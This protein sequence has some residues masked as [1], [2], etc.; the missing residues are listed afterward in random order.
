[1]SA[2]LKS[3]Q[4]SCPIPLEEFERSDR[5]FS[6]AVVM[7]GACYSDP[8]FFDFEME[9]VYGREWV[10]VGRADLIPKVGDYFTITVVGEPLIVVRNANDEIRVMSGVCRHRGMVITAS[11]QTTPDHWFDPPAETSGNCRVFRCPYH[12]WSYDLDGNLIGAPQ[13]DR[14]NDFDLNRNRLPQLK[15]ELWLGFIFVNFDQAAMP[16]APGLKELEGYVKNW[17]MDK[18]VSVHPE[19]L[20][21]LPFNWKIMVENF[22]EGYHPTRLHQGIHDWAP[23]SGAWFAPFADDAAAI[24]GAMNTIHPDGGFNPTAKALF[25]V[26]DTLTDDERNKVPFVYVPPSLLIGMQ[27]DSAFWFTVLPTGAGSHTLSMSYI[28][29]PATLKLSSFNETLEAAVQGVMAFNNQDLPTNTAVQVGMSSRFA[30][31]GQYSWQESVCAN[32]NRWLV[33]RYR[34]FDHSSAE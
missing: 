10:C 8:E 33:K 11:A 34:A 15:V 4:H 7:P 30:P 32:F 16:L 23:S 20:P 6:S 14:T 18:M 27:A 21:E 17:H 25:P 9:A 3:Q 26:I 1:M 19:T 5:D 2:R 12:W 29:P 31:R 22:M 24:Y 13:M 28:F